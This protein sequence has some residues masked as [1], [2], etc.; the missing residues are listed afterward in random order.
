MG[1]LLPTALL[2][3]STPAESNEKVSETFDDIRLTD[4]EQAEALRDAR[5]KKHYRLQA[6]EQEARA[7]EFRRKLTES[8]WNP[9]KTRQ[10]IEKRAA[11]L[12][13]DQTIAFQDLQTEEGETISNAGSIFTLLCHYFSS[14][15]G[16]YAL[17]E[18]LEV[19]RADL[20]KGLM[21]T[22]RVGC[23]KTLMMKLFQRNQRQVFMMKSAREISRKWLEAGKESGAYLED[24]CVPYPLPASDSQNFF[25]RFAGLCVDDVGT[26]DVQNNFGNKA[27]VIAEVIEG[28][29]S[30]GALG[31][32]FHLTT[33]LTGE[34][35]KNFYGVRVT[36][37]LRESMNI[38]HYKGE[39]RRK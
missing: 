16:F 22:G 25:H 18:K 1:E 21:I 6:R 3:G 13:P 7:A 24:L 17:A 26:E 5:E 39:D 31:P 20:R 32:Y 15:P 8:W 38:I 27:S 23:G 34:D 33:N 4:A 2:T 29:Y 28:R 30:N 9:D 35:F 36:S 11:I 10:W 19:K 12:F 37:R 14:D